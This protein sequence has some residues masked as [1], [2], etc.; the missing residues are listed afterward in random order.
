MGWTNLG[1]FA[2]R[3][4][5]VV[6]IDDALCHVTLSEIRHAVEA[7]RLVPMFPGV[8][9]FGGVPETWEQVVYAACRASGGYASHRTAARI[10]GI[11]YVPAQKVEI[12]VP[13]AQIVR[14]P[15]VRAH[16]SNRLPGEHIT[17]YAG[18]PITTGP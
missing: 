9:R 2:E 5:G 3:R 13:A 11:S 16:R 8:Y 15:G 18:I 14:L 10:W 7:R 1:R 6:T 17:N 12:T 4:F